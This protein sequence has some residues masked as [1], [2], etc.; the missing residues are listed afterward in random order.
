[1]RSLWSVAGPFGL[2]EA[3]SYHVRVSVM[4]GAVMVFKLSQWEKLV[5]PK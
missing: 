2:Y 3:D 5:W 4:T 1:M